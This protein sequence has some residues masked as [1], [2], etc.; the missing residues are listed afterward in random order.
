MTDPFALLIPEAKLFLRELATNNNRDWFTANKT[1]YQAELKAPAMLLQEQLTADLA[2]ITGGRVSAKLFRPQRDLR[3]S[4]DKTPYHCH[5]HM[6][7][8]IQGPVDLG[9]FLGIAPDYCTIGGGLMSFSKDQLITWRSQVD[10]PWGDKLSGELDILAQRGFRA[11]EPEL[12]RVPSSYDKT[13]PH[14]ALLRRKSLALWCEMS[15]EEQQDP[16]AVINSAHAALSPLF[17]QLT[18]ALTTT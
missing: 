11:K 10:G 12:K 1:R 15:A 17:E 16:V 14:S 5:L 9:L 4:K 13:H 7:W 3:F 2:K 8:Q 6:L 18:T